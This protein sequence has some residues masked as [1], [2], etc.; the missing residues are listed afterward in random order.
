[1]PR[2]R[3]A[4]KFRR[5]RVLWNHRSSSLLSASSMCEVAMAIPFHRASQPTEIPML[6][7]L[8]PHRSPPLL[9]VKYRITSRGKAGLK[10]WCRQVAWDYKRPTLI[11]INRY[12]IISNPRGRREI[13]NR[14]LCSKAG[15]R[16]IRHG[17]LAA[18][19]EIEERTGPFPS[20]KKKKSIHACR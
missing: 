6:K 18:P 17:I 20:T 4:C 16:E 10:G 12:C 19:Y 11:E 13:M 8:P 9:A 14:L 3:H 7:L 5:P 15:R 1:M 2:A